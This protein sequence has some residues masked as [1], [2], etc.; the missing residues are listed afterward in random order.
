[1]ISEGV[2]RFKGTELEPKFRLLEAL[3]LGKTSDLRTFK[4]ALDNTSKA[5]PN[6]EQGQLASSMYSYLEQRELQLISGEAGIDVPQTEEIADSLSKVVYNS[7]SGEHMFILL[8]PKRSDINQLK[9]NIVSFNVDYFIETDLSVA[10][11]PLNDFVEIITV[12]GF[13]DEK[14]AVKYYNLIKQNERVFSIVRKEDY[15]IFAIS[16][17]NFAVFLTD[18]SVADYLRF[19][20]E[21]YSTEN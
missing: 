8:V 20:K 16:I 21:N 19:F 17:E 9:F 18:K 3:C 4:A 7:P 12:T 1:M 13:R 6:T 15:Q 10:N 14:L 5:F 11:Q 2:V